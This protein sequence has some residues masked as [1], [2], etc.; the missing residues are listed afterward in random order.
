MNS[1]RSIMCCITA[2]E[3]CLT[4]LEKAKE[5]ADKIGC[6]VKAISV[7]P[8][9][10]E[11]ARRSADMICLN[12]LSKKSGVEIDI[13][14]SDNPLL[15]LV[16]YSEEVLPIHIYTGK[17]AENGSFVMTLAKYCKLPVSMVY[18]GQVFTVQQ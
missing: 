6:P 18:G 2:Q 15:A 1:T 9:K 11:A 8:V 4:I 10:Q 12:S 3:S 14:Y 5:M 17:Q 16:D 7:Q 13:V